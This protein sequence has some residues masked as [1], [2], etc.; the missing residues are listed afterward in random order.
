MGIA[1]PWVSA[2]DFVT[3]LDPTYGSATV[4]A[5]VPVPA[6][7]WFMLSGLAALFGIRRQAA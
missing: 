5:V 3:E 6:A 4:N 1:G 7:V 2:A